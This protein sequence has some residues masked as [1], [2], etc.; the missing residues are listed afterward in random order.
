MPCAGHRGSIE[1]D[2]SVN[3]NVRPGAA[4]SDG[5][6]LTTSDLRFGIQSTSQLA[7]SGTGGPPAVGNAIVT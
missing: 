5:G 4:G 6:N 7:Q 1:P 2:S 3:M